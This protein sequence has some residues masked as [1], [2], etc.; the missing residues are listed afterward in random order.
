MFL[1]I[2]EY[3]A[4]KHGYAEG[5]NTAV[6]FYPV[7]VVYADTPAE[8]EFIEE[9]NPRQSPA[10]FSYSTLSMVAPNNPEIVFDLFFWEENGFQYAQNHYHAPE[11]ADESSYLIALV[12]AKP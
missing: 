7:Y 6:L 10:S 9:A 8:I 5:V 3:D 12:R 4:Q 1:E 2:E 11:G